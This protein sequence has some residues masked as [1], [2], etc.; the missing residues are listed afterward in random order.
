MDYKRVQCPNAAWLEER[1]LVLFTL[2][3]V[4]TMR[5]T[6]M[7]VKAVKKVVAAYRK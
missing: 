1:A 3:P 2:Q 5:H 6:S 4:Y 7:V